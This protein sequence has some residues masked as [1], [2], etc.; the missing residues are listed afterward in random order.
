MLRSGAQWRLLPKEYGKW[1][2]VYRRF[3]RWCEAGIGEAMLTHF[4]GD[5]DMESVLVD[6]TIVRAQPCAAG[7]AK[8][9]GGADAQ[10]LGRSRGG[11]TCKVHASVDA[12]GNP[13]RLRLTPGQ[14][15]ESTQPE[16]LL[17]G[18]QTSH[19][20]ADRGDAAQ[21][22]IDLILQHQAIPVI[23]PHQPAKVQRDYDTW[24]YRER[25][26]S[27]CFF[28]KLK[29]FRRV[30]SRFDKLASRFSGFVHFASTLVWL[31]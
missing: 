5:A 8:K 17:T 13:L 4:A 3:A 21:T 2:S 29:Q 20:I 9:N 16:A 11:F 19:V 10:A 31:R 1:N 14:R 12:P 24:R 6:A 7:A 30:F 22:F 18:F 25:H 23:P 26:L 28:N 15:H 27:D